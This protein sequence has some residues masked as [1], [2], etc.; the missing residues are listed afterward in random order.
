[1]LNLWSSAEDISSKC[2]RGTHEESHLEPIGQSG[3]NCK[4]N[5]PE[6]TGEFFKKLRPQALQ[7][8]IS[9]EHAHRYPSNVSLFIENEEAKYVFVVIEGAVRLSINSSDGRRLSLRMARKDDILGLAPVLSGTQ[10]EVTAETRYP[11]TIACITRSELLGFLSRHPEVYQIVLEEMGRQLNAVCDQLRTVGLSASV[12]E[13]L[14]RLL[15]EWSDTEQ[16]LECGFV[17][18]SLT[19]EEIAEFVGA[20]R[21]TVTR[22]L[23]RFK[24][25]RLVLFNGSTF[26][27]PSRSALEGYAKT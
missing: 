16:A 9:M 19:H 26:T 18:F 5:R 1:M 17:R 4:N 27:I 12:S 15:L 7:D 8:L 13:K 6:H 25:H 3:A 11:T 10:H 20:S 24:H 2:L 23:S 21:E 14:A 22:I